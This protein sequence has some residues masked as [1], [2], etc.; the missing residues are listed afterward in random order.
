MTLVFSA[1][2]AGAQTPVELSST[3]LPTFFVHPR[4]TRVVSARHSS[5]ETA[6][7]TRRRVDRETNRLTPSRH[8]HS[9]TASRGLAVARSDGRG[10]SCG[11]VQLRSARQRTPAKLRTHHPRAPTARHR[12]DLPA[13]PGI[14]DG[15]T[16][17]ALE[18]E[19][20]L[21]L[22]WTTPEGGRLM[23]WA[24]V[25]EE[26]EHGSTRLIVR[27]RVGPGAHVFGLR[28]WASNHIVAGIHFIMQ[29]KQL[30]R[31][32]AEQSHGTCQRTKQRGSP[33]RLSSE[34]IRYS[35]TTS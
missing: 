17:L 5:G 11:L 25:L 12:H 27:V 23:T 21:V 13:A 14:T 19:R 31:E 35:R 3:P 28:W 26:A 8:H 16:L 18:P 20:F 33:W 1:T 9:T 30:H 10:Q 29:R 24:F 32:A 15:F 22:G 6:R 2:G 7:V 4:A 34:G